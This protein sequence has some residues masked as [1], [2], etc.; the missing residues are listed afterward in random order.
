MPEVVVYDEACIV[1]YRREDG[2]EI[3]RGSETLLPRRFVATFPDPKGGPETLAMFEMR[4]G[5]PECRE[6]RLVARSDG[7]EVRP[8][9]VRSINIEELLDSAS[10]LVA[11]HPTELLEGGG[12]VAEH[13]HGKADLALTRDVVGA[14]R[15]RNTRRR[16][17]D[18]ELAEVAEIYRANPDAPTQAVARRYTIAH[19]TASLYVKRAREA[20]LL[21]RGTDG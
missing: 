20:G 17:S 13:A 3:I 14:A 10:E 1:R 11:I 8:V 2:A 19:R 6:V 9:D 15:K 21:G 12:V 16:I 7:R 5:V 4:A 18:D